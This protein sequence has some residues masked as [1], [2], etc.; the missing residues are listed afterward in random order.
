MSAP[1]PPNNPSR[2]Q[3]VH[4]EQVYQAIVTLHE[5]GRV[6]TRDRLSDVIEIT[7]EKLDEHLRMLKDAR[8]IRPIERGVFVPIYEFPPPR[9][10]SLTVLPNGYA[11]VDLGDVVFDLTPEEARTFGMMMHGYAAAHTEIQSYREMRG[12]VADQDARNREMVSSTKDVIRNIERL[13]MN[14]VS[15]GHANAN[16]NLLIEARRRANG[17]KPPHLQKRTEG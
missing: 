11:K 3:T 12:I 2:T 4:R 6:A 7:P 14:L 17:K 8:R 5:S 15:G 13:A 16:A 1:T 10:M 9:A